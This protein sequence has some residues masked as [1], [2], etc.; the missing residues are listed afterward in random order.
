MYNSDFAGLPSSVSHLHFGKFYNRPIINLP[1]SIKS[2]QFGSF[3]SAPFQ[4]PQSVTHLT[5]GIFFKDKITTLPLS[6][7]HLTFQGPYGL[8]IIPILPP[9]LK[10]FSNLCGAIE[11]LINLPLNLEYLAISDSNQPLD[12]LPPRLTCIKLGRTFKQPL[13]NLPPS[14]TSLS[15]EKASKFKH[16]V[17]KLPP[18]VTH[19]TF[20]DSYTQP[21]SPP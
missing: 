18:S 11:P 17:N 12:F 14:L 19:L 15:F 3:F 1:P 2:I 5:F 4:L 10:F 16:P 8:P 7:T 20:G 9:N 13:D 6:L 21:L